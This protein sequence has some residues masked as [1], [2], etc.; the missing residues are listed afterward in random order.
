MKILTVWDSEYPWD[1]RIEKVTDALA[2]AGHEVHLLARNRNSRPRY[3]RGRGIHIHRTTSLPHMPRLINGAVTFP[4]FFNPVWL[5]SLRSLAR[6]ADL[7]IVRD[8][9]LAPAALLIGRGQRV[10]V[11]LDMAEC[12]PE[13]LR[14]MWRFSG[15]RP[16]DLVVRN[17]YLAD[18]VERNVVPRMDHVLVMVEESRARLLKM[19]VDPSRVSVVSNTPVVERFQNGAAFRHD[20]SDGTLELVYVGILGFSRGLAAFISGVARYSKENPRVHLSIYGTGRAMGDLER[21]IRDLDAAGVVS[22]RG[23]LPNQKLPEVL[24]ESHV[25]VIPHI[26]C[27]HWDHTVP[28]KLFDYMAAG[29]PVLATDAVPVARIVGSTGAGVIYQESDSEDVLRALRDLS[30]PVL[31]RRMGERGRR[32]VETTFNWDQDKVVLLQAVRSFDRSQ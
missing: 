24:R 10:P 22:L 26:R 19:G 4:A 8:L 14:A 9:P 29:L 18:V 16:L 27:S 13:M 12:Y 5:A 6:T 31:R 11:V 28:N 21:R 25:G 23:Y 2:E 32:A 15:I 20:C 30:D 1:V 7:I 17:P 3:E